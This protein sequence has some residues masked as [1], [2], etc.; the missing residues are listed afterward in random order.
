MRREW[1]K[2]DAV[3]NIPDLLA[4]RPEP[5]SEKSGSS[6]SNTRVGSAYHATSYLFMIMPYSTNPP[7]PQQAAALRQ[8]NFDRLWERSPSRDR[9]GRL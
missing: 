9:Q 2:M 5:V 7:W 4:G 1:Q 3:E 6:T 8:V